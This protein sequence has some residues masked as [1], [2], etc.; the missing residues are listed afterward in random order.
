MELLY[1]KKVRS[2]SEQHESNRFTIVYVHGQS[3]EIVEVHQVDM[4]SWLLYECFVLPTYC[5]HYF[6]L[7]RDSETIEWINMDNEEIDNGILTLSSELLKYRPS[8]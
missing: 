4:G 5:T 3:T 7:E 8:A 1:M 6:S 2:T